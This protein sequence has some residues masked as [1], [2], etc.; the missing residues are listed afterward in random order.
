MTELERI[1]R[2]H[3]VEDVQAEAIETLADVSGTR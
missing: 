2:E 3:P 1:L